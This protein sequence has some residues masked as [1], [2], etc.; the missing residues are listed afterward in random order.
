MSDVTPAAWPGVR[1]PSPFVLRSRGWASAVTR[2]WLSTRVAFGHIAMIVVASTWLVHGLYNKLLGGS[3]RHLMIV[4]ATPGLDG[5]AGHYALAAIGVVEV[6]LAGWVLTGCAPR[7]CAATQTLVL[8]SMNVVELAFARD[9]LLW[10][11]GLIPMNLGFLA[12]AWIGACGGSAASLRVRGRRHPFAVR[13]RFRECLTLT[14]AFPADVLRPLLP[15]GLELDTLRGYGFAAVALVRT[16]SLRPAG[17]PQAFGQDFFLSGYRVFARVRRPDGRR[18]RGLRILRSDTD[19]LRMVIGGNLFT[20]YNYHRC[21]AAVDTSDSRLRVTI[22][23]RDGLADLDV[24]A[25]PDSPELPEGSPFESWKEA[26]RYAGPLPFT[27]DSEAE[28]H[29]I[30][31]I[32]AA[33]TRWQPTPVNVDVRA[34]SFFDH[35]VFRG[36][37]PILAAAFAVSDVDYEWKRGVRLPLKPSPLPEVP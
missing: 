5:P 16:E 11:A 23:T 21:E 33:R 4:Q 14:Y 2:W 17:W 7:L 1:L 15:P 30:I 25:W 26:R 8:L 9:L 28:T 34:M 18:L 3:P 13:A 31:A 20:H 37:A 19:R 24:S 36:A 35:G 22:C 10:P 6:A 12:L 27:F 32:E 29:S